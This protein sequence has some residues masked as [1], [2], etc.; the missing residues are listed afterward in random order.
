MDFGGWKDGEGWDLGG[1]G[2]RKSVI[3]IHAMKKFNKKK[4]GTQ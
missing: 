4:K 2:R 3:R 1:V